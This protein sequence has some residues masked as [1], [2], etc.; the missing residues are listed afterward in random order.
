MS[1]TETNEMATVEKKDEM[2]V[3]D[4]SLSPTRS[5][6]ELSEEEKEKVEELYGK[7]EDYSDVAL[8]NFTSGAAE[9]SAREADEFLRKTKINDLDEFNECMT[10]LT[11]DLRSVDTKELASQ[12]PSPIARIPIIGQKLAQSRIGKK[13]ESVIE[14]QQTVKK[15][16][17]TT[18]LTLEEIKMTLRE[19]LIRCAATREKTVAFAK[20]LEFEYIALYRKREEL[21]REYQ[22]FISSPKYNPNDLD[23]SEYSAKLQDGIQAIERKMDNVLRYRINAIQNIPSL[24]LVKNTEN[25]LIHSIDD[26]IKNVIPEWNKAFL[27]AILAYR[28]ANASKVVGS[29]QN[30]TNEIL[31]TAAE[32]TSHA[33]LSTAEVVEKPQIASETLEKKTQIFIDTCNQLVKIA[34]DASKKRAEDAIRL[35]EIETKS[36]A[37]KD[38]RKTIKLID[39]KGE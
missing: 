8:I 30:A 2:I 33:I 21:E 37:A 7:L 5:F 10:G 27:Q 9:E 12:N 17:D 15:A 4:N 24:A 31:I 23:D 32:A 26:C 3:V 34:Q 6:S 35:K 14:K 11:R 25:A 38:E 39:K 22:E 13:V 19:D 20:E 36:I 16:V 18:V 1:K 28:V 29:V